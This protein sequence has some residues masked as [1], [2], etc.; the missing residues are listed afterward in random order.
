MRSCGHLDAELA[1][2]PGFEAPVREVLFATEGSAEAAL[3]DRTGYAQSGLFAVQVALVELLRS[4]GMGPDVVLGHSVG[5]F[6]AAYVA[7]VFELADAAR[8]VATRGRLM[9]ALP[10][11]GAMAAIEADEAEVVEILEVLSG[12][13]PVAVA[14]VNGPTSVVVSGGEDAVER[15]MA[16]ARERGRRVSRLRV[17]HA[18]HSP[19]MEPMLAEF[20]EVAAGVTYRQPVL[21]AVSTVT[22]QPLAD[23]D[24]TTPA[25]WVRQ[26][27]EPVRFH[28]ALRTAAGEQA[29]TRLLEI[30]PD[31][32][33]TALAAARSG[34]CGFG[35]AKG[36]RRGRDACW[37][38]WPS[39]SYEASRWTGP[40]S[41]LGPVRG[42]WICR[43][44][45]FSGS[46]SG[47]GPSGRRPISTAWVWVRRGI[48]CWVLRLRWRVRMRCC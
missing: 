2:R 18:F 14:A 37:V 43:R 17:S 40:P 34:H 45:R 4:W 48:R 13:E 31:P 27:R 5:E 23:G 25:Y 24:W 1:G 12:G 36:T 41:S 38:P 10:A 11:G 7:G 35:A 46:V 6:V 19:L 26:V 30:G 8:L 42:E 44:M 16:V 32:V 21:T 9:Q 22:G 28:D 47:C 33:L 3:L 29:A 39:C 20:A 15:V